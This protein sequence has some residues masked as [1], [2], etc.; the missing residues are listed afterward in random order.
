[1]SLDAMRFTVESV[2][3]SGMTAAYPGVPL[4]FQ[5][6]DLPLPRGIHATLWLIEGAAH[7]ANFGGKIVDRHIG[8][9]NVV[10][11]IPV[12]EGTSDANKIAECAGNLFRRKEFTLSDGAVVRFRIPQFGYTA[13]VGGFAR[14]TARIAYWRDEVAV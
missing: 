5:N 14:V 13:D 7:E 11:S 8:M 9:V 10:V 4:G 6:A 12:R 1:M 3:K 2:F